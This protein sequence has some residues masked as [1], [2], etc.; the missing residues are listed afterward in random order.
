MKD[1]SLKF[2]DSRFHPLRF[3]TARQGG[4][5]WHGNRTS[6]SQSAWQSQSAWFVRCAT[7]LCRWGLAV[8]SPRTG[9][10]WFCLTRFPTIN[11]WAIIGRPC[12]TL[13]VRSSPC[14]AQESV[15][16]P[17]MCQINGFRRKPLILSAFINFYQVLTIKKRFYAMNHTNIRV[18]SFKFQVSRF[19]TADGQ[20]SSRRALQRKNKAFG[21]NR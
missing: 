20:H 14:L 21:V 3:A 4:P 10:G 7:G 5:G 19:Q 17:L 16:Q 15:L 2:Q 12:G 11:R 13:L 18:G 6:A 1:S 8:L 9:L